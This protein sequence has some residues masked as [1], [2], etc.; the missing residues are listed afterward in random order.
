[1]KK[2]TNTL[3]ES[4]SSKRPKRN[5]TINKQIKEN[6]SESDDESSKR[7]PKRNLN[8][9]KKLKKT[10]NE[11]DTSETENETSK[12]RTPKRTASKS[13]KVIKD[14]SESEYEPEGENP[15]ESDYEPEE[16]NISDEVEDEIEEII[17]DVECEQDLNSSIISSKSR[18]KRTKKAK[19]KY[20][21]E[22]FRSEVK[23]IDEFNFETK[24]SEWE[25]EPE[26]NCKL[27]C[28]PILPALS[29]LAIK[30]F[31]NSK[32]TKKSTIYDCP[33]CHIHFTYNLVFKTHLFSCSKNPNV[34]E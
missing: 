16:E 30:P 13:K 29:D 33:F 32:S 14:T 9:N 26:P 3:N 8:Q 11:E 7:R 19:E 1:M 18:P 25:Y 34:P 2:K 22:S 27:Y 31:L 28:R 12:R 21:D 6:K 4:D 23:Q 20:Q 10:V 24:V 5:S 15:T 17:S